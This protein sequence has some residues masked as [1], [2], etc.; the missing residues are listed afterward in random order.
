MQLKAG[1]F[2][3]EEM[4]EALFQWPIASDGTWTATPLP[5]C[6]GDI[7]KLLD[8]TTGG[9]TEGVS[10]TLT[11]RKELLSDTLPEAEQY[12]RLKPYGYDWISL[13]IVNPSI[14]T[15]GQTLQLMCVSMNQ[16]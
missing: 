5:C 1:N 11:L 3:H 8:L 4:Y 15:G 12:C 9:F 7:S 13:K 2:I 10:V 14:P 16:R 6:H